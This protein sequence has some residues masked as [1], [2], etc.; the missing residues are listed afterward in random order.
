NRPMASPAKTAR[1]QVYIRPKNR[2][3]KTP[4]KS[5]HVSQSSQTYSCAGANYLPNHPKTAW[6]AVTSIIF[7]FLN[8][9]LLLKINKR[10]SFDTTAG[11]RRREFFRSSCAADLAQ[12]LH[13]P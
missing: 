7:S 9:K 3:F 13:I 1:F 8:A 12:I 2:F 11:R 5:T 6:F 4:V 10:A